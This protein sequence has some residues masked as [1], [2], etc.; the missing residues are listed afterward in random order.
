MSI[1]DQTMRKVPNYYREMYLDGFTPEEIMYAHKKLMRE[2][3]MRQSNA[4]ES[5]SEE[6]ILWAVEKSLTPAV[7]KALDDI[8]KDWK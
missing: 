2:K 4:E 6:E 3:M 8:F 5:I 7:H 1:I